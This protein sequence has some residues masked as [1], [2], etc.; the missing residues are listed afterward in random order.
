MAT[1][2]DVSAHKI[3]ANLEQAPGRDRYKTRD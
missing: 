3:E 2:H 1:R